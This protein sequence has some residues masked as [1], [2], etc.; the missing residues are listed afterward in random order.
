MTKTTPN[1]LGLIPARGGSK[2]IPNKNIIY[3]Q[4]KPLIH[5]TI[6]AALTAS[7]LSDVIVSTDSQTIADISISAGAAI[8]FLRPANFSNDKSNALDVVQHAINHFANEN[9]LYDYIVYLQPTSPLRSNEDIDNSIAMMLESKADSL[10][11]T[12]DVPHQFSPESLMIENSGYVSPAQTS[13]SKLRRQDKAAFVARNGPA[14]LITKPSTIN[15][16]NSLYGETIAAYKMPAN[17]SVDIDSIE[18]LDYA[19]WLIGK[20]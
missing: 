19:S 15:K 17:R 8:P 11:S 10:V 14:I 2:G 12:M 7:T 16:F 13:T 6:D 5:Y 18:D 9:T 3:V 20:N 4:G 1:I